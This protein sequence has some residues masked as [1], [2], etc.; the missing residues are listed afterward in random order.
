MSDVITVGDSLSISTRE[1]GN[2]IQIT[3][4]VMHSDA[5]RTKTELQSYLFSFLVE[6]VKVVHTR[7]ETITIDQNKFILL[8]PGHYLMTE[9]MASSRGIFQTVLLFFT[10]EA[11]HSFLSQ[12]PSINL[13][14]SQPTIEQAQVFS[15]DEFLK[16]FIHSMLL[17]LE[18]GNEIPSAL[19][20]VKL[21]ELLLYLCCHYPEKMSSLKAMASKTVS[22]IEMRK[23]I[24]ANIGRQIKLEELAFLANM[25]LSTFKRRFIDL[26]GIAPSKWFLQRRMEMATSLLRTGKEKPSEIY[27]KVGYESHSSFTHSFKQ[28]FGVTPTEYRERIPLKFDNTMNL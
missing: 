23:L 14:R 15:K 20:K 13:A 7:K 6:G 17:M 12:Y 28:V 25:S 9:T 11:I 24:E 16:N 10:Q 26:Y 2:G 1:K 22:E 21:H 27:Y 5:V 18:H 4:H 3:N 8:L 19:Q